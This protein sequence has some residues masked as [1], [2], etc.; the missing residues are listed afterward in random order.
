M[1]KHFKCGEKP[2][3]KRVEDM[4]KNLEA[5]FKQDDSPTTKEIM[6]G[7]VFWIVIGLILIY[8][9]YSFVNWYS[10]TS[11]TQFEQCCC[12]CGGQCYQQ[13]S[14]KK[15]SLGTVL[16]KFFKGFVKEVPVYSWW[17]CWYLWWCETMAVLSKN[18]TFIFFLTFL[19]L[20]PNVT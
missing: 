18:R 8:A 19:L 15:P 12:A 4:V 3:Q 16:Y 9:G 1:K 13:K 14:H 17:I 7:V 5:L 20:M 11:V 6:F 2:F 10:D